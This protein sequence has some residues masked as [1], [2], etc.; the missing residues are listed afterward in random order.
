M[1][2]VSGVTDWVT[3]RLKAALNDPEACDNAGAPG[4]SASKVKVPVAA[5]DA[6]PEVSQETT[7]IIVVRRGMVIDPPAATD[8]PVEQVG[9]AGVPVAALVK[10]KSWKFARGMDSLT[11]TVK[12]VLKV[13]DAIEIVGAESAD[14]DGDGEAEGDGDALAP[15]ETA[16]A[17]HDVGA[18]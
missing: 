7:E 18:Q 6:N 13:V 11:V 5:L 10:R 15:P 3:T 12:P 2:V 14:G 16:H 8:V 17:D 4:A 1:K 9:F